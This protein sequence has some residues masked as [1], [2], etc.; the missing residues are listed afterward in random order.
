MIAYSVMHPSLPMGLRSKKLEDAVVP[1]LW[2][3]HH[4]EM[5]IGQI[6]STELNDSELSAVLSFA[7]SEG[8]QLVYLATRPGRTLPQT[9][10]KNFSGLLVDRKMTFRK[11]VMPEP[12]PDLV[13][14]LRSTLTI[15]EYNQIPATEQLL[16]LAVQSGVHSRFKVDP[17]I[18]IDKFES[19][20]H[21][22]MNR[23]VAHDLADIVF[24]AVHPSN[25]HQYLG[26]ITA[27]LEHG[28]GKI[29]LICVSH[30]YQGKG[31][32]ALLMYAVH[33]WMD[34]HAIKET[35]VVTQ[36]DNLA[37]CKLY[38]RLGYRLA[39]QQ[40]VYHFWVQR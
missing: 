23:S 19:M 26:V 28:I 1:L 4:F 18:P 12:I 17:N 25:N 32:G 10:F 34:S 6:S 31:I 21:I 2:D 37:A 39:S 15:A 40:H 9:I 11:K 30:D 16:G 33:Q 35:V 38:A 22:W 14:N 27:S 8:F 24:V 13:E 7:K 5:S 20:F 29:G 36:R 3:S